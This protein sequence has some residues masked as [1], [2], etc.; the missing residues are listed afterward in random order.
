MRIET[1][2]TSRDS[3]RHF[4]FQQHLV[5]AMNSPRIF[6][7]FPRWRHVVRSLFKQ[8]ALWHWL[9][10]ILLLH[11][12]NVSA[13]CEKFFIDVLVASVDVIEAVDLGGSLCRESG[14]YECSGGS[15]VRCHD[16]GGG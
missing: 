1:S 7:K 16:G 2:F 6:E 5:E 11:P 13:E 15:E 8:S 12:L 3:S 10:A 9:I 14:E 4:V